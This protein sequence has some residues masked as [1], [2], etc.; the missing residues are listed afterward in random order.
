[1]AMGKKVMELLFRVKAKDAK[2]DIKEVGDGLKKVGTTGKIAQGGLN[3]M[4]KGFKGIGVAMKAAGIG[5]FIG[6]LSQLT[7]LFQSNQKT[8]D[9]FQRIMLKLQPVFDTVGKVI[10]Y[11]A[12]ALEFLIDLF[13][14][15]IGWIGDFIGVT[16]GA[17]SSTDNF[18]ES[19]VNQRK[20]VQLLEAELGLLQLQYQKEA[21][22]MRQIRD[23]ESLS[24]EERIKANF[25]LGKVLEEQL[26]HERS[27]AEQSLS[28]AEMELSV[29]KDNIELQTAVIDAKTKLAEI[30][31]RITGQRS[32]Q[33]TN[34]NS[35]NREREAQQKEAAAKREEQLKKEAEMLQN[36]IDLQN[37][38]IKVTK[39]KFRT[40]NEQFD[41]AEEQNQKQI[42]EL[43]RQMNAELN[44]HKT[45][46]KNA[47]ENI[48]LQKEE[49]KVQKDSI[50]ENIAENEKR[51][52]SEEDL[53]AAKMTLI[54]AALRDAS[55]EKF[56]GSFASGSE[57]ALDELLNRQVETL[58]DMQ[59]FQDDYST[60]TEK[61]LEE[62]S[63][64]IEKKYGDKILKGITESFQ[65]QGAIIVNAQADLKRQLENTSDF[66]EENSIAI[67]EMSEE[68]AAKSV[69]VVENASAEELAIRA[70][71]AKEIEA[72]EKSLDDT[73]LTL[74]E[75]ANLELALHFETAQE[76]E[77]R[78]TEEKYDRLLGLA[79]ND[80][81]MT[82]DLENEKTKRLKEIED[83][84][85][86][87]AEGSKISFMS[88][89][90]AFNKKLIDK[91]INLEKKKN[92][93]AQQSLQMGMQLAGEGSAAGKA[94]AIANTIIA[95]K[96]GAMQVFDDAE[97]PTPLKWIQAGLIIATGLK[98][99]ADIRKTKIPGGT[100]GPGP[101]MD[102]D[103]S[104]G[105]DVSGAVPTPTFG[106]IEADA[107][108]VQAFV[109]ESDVSGAQALQSELD[110]QSTL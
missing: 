24:I 106:A 87:E 36:L 65:S 7:G 3:L 5:L 91:E 99:I 31:E 75:Q 13:T 109:V 22:L 108:P 41:N 83:K 44:A 71:Y 10:E 46:V 39:E 55:I 78:E 16:D 40:I 107:P 11:A 103:M 33:L 53:V 85:Q 84:Y 57:E 20:Q 38:D 8:A 43:N 95:T 50:A 21:E 6:L 32:E 62:S 90:L 72:T 4:G 88:K 63:Q 25:E 37:E 18:A 100:D 86:K 60:L 14:G 80:A 79:L 67:I 35:L 26:I 98:T 92:Q 64:I 66:V 30:D 51:A 96:A 19:L 105:G 70:K 93:A 94:L 97:M 59:K 54:K 49:V 61:A 69:Q 34:L 48:D 15:A 45:R 81:Q 89:M 101:S 17:A 74:Q 9:T 110:L 42:D 77:L 56:V 76:K 29:N 73:T 27:I 12:G 28:L 102:D 47:K 23:D 58:D 68:S 2:Q 1:M 104:S 82:I 52:K